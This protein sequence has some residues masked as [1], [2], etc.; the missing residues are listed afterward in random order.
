[1]ISN[2]LS[3]MKIQWSSKRVMWWAFSTWLQHAMTTMWDSSIFKLWRWLRLLKGEI[4]MDSHFLLM[5]VQTDSWLL[6]ALKMI[7]LLLILLRWKSWVLISTLFLLSGE[8]DTRISSLQ[9]NLILISRLTT[10]L[11]YKSNLLS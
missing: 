10:I 8:L 6:L 4:I 7:R 3:C 11:I 9:L 5:S 1:M 2:A